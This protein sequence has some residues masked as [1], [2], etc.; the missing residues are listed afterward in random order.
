LPDLAS[1]GTLI[2]MALNGDLATFGLADLLQWMES[3]KAT[4]CASLFGDG[5][6]RRLFVQD[7]S[8]IAVAYP[9]QWERLARQLVGAELTS[10]DNVGMA[11]ARVRRGERAFAAAL[12]EV[13]IG[14]EPCGD[15]A[16]DDLKSAVATA[17]S[18]RTGRFAFAEET[19]PHPGDEST[20]LSL[21]L[22]ELLFEGIRHADEQTQVDQV[23]G[24]DTAPVVPVSGQPLPSSAAQR[25]VLAQVLRHPGGTTVGAV[26]MALAMSRTACARHVYELY[27]GGRVRLPGHTRPPAPDPLAALL[28]Q[29]SGLLR[30]GELEAA[31][32]LCASLRG[33]DPTDRRVR[34]FSRAVEGEQVARLYAAL[35]PLQV[36]ERVPGLEA[37][38]KRLRADE[39]QV[40]QLI[41]GV[42]DV[43]TVALASPHRELETLKA[44]SRLRQMGLVRPAQVA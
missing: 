25:A 34:E 3:A 18:Q 14:G 29:G 32:L 37:K 43:A 33:A 35:L 41:N 8:L 42:W 15:L 6:E 1:D 4:G 40:L 30:S 7:G 44:L 31:G 21:S 5:V 22:R 10:A 39:R 9:G 20:D 24:D 16:A 26:R 23:V 19:L 38:G 2:A 28:S 12:A 13:G 27:L 11:L 36:Y 17:M